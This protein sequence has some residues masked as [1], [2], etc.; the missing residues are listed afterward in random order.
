[1]LAVFQEYENLM[2]GFIIIV[3]MVFMRDGVVPMAWKLIA[4]AR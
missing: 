1:V 2:L 3:S 4:R